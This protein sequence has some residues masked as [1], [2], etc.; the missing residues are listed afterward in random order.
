MLW[1]FDFLTMKKVIIKK[2]KIGQFEKGVFSNRN[3][4]KGEI[5]IRYHLKLLTKKK[6]ENLPKKDKNFVHN[7]HGKLFL[8]SSPERYINHSSNPN[9]IQDIKNRC[10]VALRNI[11]KN[12][13]VT[14]NSEKDDVFQLI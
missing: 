2:S 4:K 3:F 9:I 8:Y 1:K 10:D 11:K 7:H 13:E 6:F 12:E 14:T 5:V